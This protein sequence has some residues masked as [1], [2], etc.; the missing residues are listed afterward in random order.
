MSSDAHDANPGAH[1]RHS[2]LLTAIRLSSSTRAERIGSD[3]QFIEF[4]IQHVCRDEETVDTSKT[5]S[6]D[7]V[8][9]FWPPSAAGSAI[10]R[11]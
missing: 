7:L 8:H 1:A 5:L 6:L 9:A 4:L 11:H 3:S 10:A 2:I